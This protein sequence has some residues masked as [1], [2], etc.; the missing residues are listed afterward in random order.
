MQK[1]EEKKEKNIQKSNTIISRSDNIIEGL[2]G[3]FFSKCKSFDVLD[4]YNKL[5]YTIIP[6]YIRVIGYGFL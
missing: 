6:F 2:F 5:L 3:N 1:K 4:F